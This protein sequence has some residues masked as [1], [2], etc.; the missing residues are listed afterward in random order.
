MTEGLFCGARGRTGEGARDGASRC[1]GTE[2]AVGLQQQQQQ[3]EEE[4]EERPVSEAAK[5]RARRIFERAH[6]SMKERELK[7][8]RVTL[9][10][11][12]L[13]FERAHGS[14]ADVE[15]IQKQMPRKTKKKRRL[16]DDSWEEY[17]D[18]VFP[19][20]DQQAQGLSNLL[21]AAQAWKQTG[22]NI[23]AAGG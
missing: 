6:K 8:E 22:G 4:E 21:A 1:G 18:Y 19:A 5:A 15:A 16:D 23:G 17:V 13:A 10:S 20:D 3:E 12:W 2:I 14:A 9:L 11:A 7:A